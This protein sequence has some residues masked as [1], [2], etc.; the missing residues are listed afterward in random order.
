VKKHIRHI[1]KVWRGIRRI[2][3]YEKK[4]G[5]DLIGLR[6]IRSYPVET[7]PYA[8]KMH[9]KAHPEIS[10]WASLIVVSVL[11]DKRTS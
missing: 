7:Q 8:P 11:H 9:K 6:P 1:W 3:K 4:L 5:K 2:W 10:E